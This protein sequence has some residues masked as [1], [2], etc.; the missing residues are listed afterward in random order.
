MFSK[1]KK[2]GPGDNPTAPELKSIPGGQDRPVSKTVHRKPDTG[3]ELT[4]TRRNVS[5]NVSRVPGQVAPVDK[6]RK[7]KEE[8]LGE[9]KLE[10]HRRL[11]DNLN[12]SA[13]DT[14]TEE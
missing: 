13:L 6:E 14:A 1:Y 8:R 11:L 12:L 10:L 2:G 9:I 4:A 5:R 7:R 3:T